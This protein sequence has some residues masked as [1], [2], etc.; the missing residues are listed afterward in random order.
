MSSWSNAFDLSC[1]SCL[2]AFPPST[3][4]TGL[5][6]LE[7]LDLRQ[8]GSIWRGSDGAVSGEIGQSRRIGIT[9]EIDSPLWF[10]VRGNR[11]VSASQALNRCGK[12]RF[13]GSKSGHHSAGI[14]ANVKAMFG[15]AGSRIQRV[16]RLR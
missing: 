4:E 10:Y 16:S 8:A 13:A 3:L 15:D 5:T 2:A 9:R 7:G 12:Q 11:F 14:L 6:R 1:D